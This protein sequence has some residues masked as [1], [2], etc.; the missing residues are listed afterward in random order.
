MSKLEP[1][2]ELVEQLLLQL[3]RPREL[4][5]AL[6][7]TSTVA[8]DLHATRTGQNT[9]YTLTAL[10]RQSIY[11]RLAEYEDCG[12][13]EGIAYNGHFGYTCYHPLFLFNRF[14]DLECVMPRWGNR[15]NTK[16]WRRM[17][18][19]VMERYRGF[20]I[21]PFFRGDAAFAGPKLLRLLEREE[22]RY[23][24][25][26]KANAVLERKLAHLLKRPL[27]RPSHKPKVFYANF[28]YQAKSWV[29]PA[30]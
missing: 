4:D 3:H 13:Q 1:A 27:S 2:A 9:Q 10:L 12:H 20:K 26:I 28:R 19:L 11:S 23:A 22:F 7:R 17:L 18:L 29:L 6:G 5:D 30:G 15:T 16:Y 14:G 25:R 8:S 21:P 24:M